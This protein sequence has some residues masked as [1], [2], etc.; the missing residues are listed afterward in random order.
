MVVSKHKQPH[1]EIL[2]STV[3]HTH[4]HTHIHTPWINLSHVQCTCHMR[5]WYPSLHNPAPDL[6]HD[7]TQYFFWSGIQPQDLCANL[8]TTSSCCM[9]ETIL[10]PTEHLLQAHV[11]GT[12]TRHM[13]QAHVP[14]TCTRRMYQA[15]VPGT[16]TRH[17][18]QIVHCTSKHRLNFDYT[19]NMVISIEI[20]L[21]KFISGN[22]IYQVYQVIS[23]IRYIR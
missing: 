4:T 1:G 14:G 16:C 2:T 12:C 9:I 5:W 11:P 10:L 15:H 17:K 13:Y 21:A 20:H 22:I 6:G 18:V 8:R 19:C 23:Y 7:I 3:T